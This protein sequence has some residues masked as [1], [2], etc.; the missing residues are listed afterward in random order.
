[1]E[2]EQYVCTVCGYNMAGYYPG[3]CP[4]CGAGRE[5]FITSEECSGSFHVEGTEVNEYVTRLSSI[6]SLGLEHAA[7]RVE[8]DETI[9]WIDCPSSFDVDVRSMD[10]IMFTH[11]HFL[12]AS[13]QYRNH[14]TSEVR[15][16]KAD[17]S[18]ELC[19]GFTFDDTFSGD[20][21]E[22]GID[23]FHIGGHT[24]GFTFYIHR[25]TLF[26]CDYVFFKEGDMRFN[27]FGPERETGQG[28]K[29]LREL[30]TDRNLNTVCGYNYISDYGKWIAA[31]D[32]LLS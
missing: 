3:H 28:G 23:A 26:V 2:T 16:H 22:S 32:R 29:R 18:F 14:F 17:S 31:F 1:M 9:F 27:S 7:Y 5:T 10:V 13:N 24:P 30:I 11:H 19:R 21:S 8:T 4:F 6:P 12:G 25:D 15:I 20:F